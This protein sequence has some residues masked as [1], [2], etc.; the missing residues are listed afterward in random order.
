MITGS[1]NPIEF[2]GFKMQVGKAA[3][4]GEEIM[5]LARRIEE[6]D[7]VEGSG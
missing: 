1:H 5:D 4:H 7:F 6:E 3:I 2:N